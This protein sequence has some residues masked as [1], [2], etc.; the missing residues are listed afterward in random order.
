MTTKHKLNLLMLIYSLGTACL[1]II[2]GFNFTDSILLHT[3][4]FALIL[5]MNRLSYG[6]NRMAGQKTRYSMYATDV[7]FI[8]YL[9]LALILGDSHFIQYKLLIIPGIVLTLVQAFGFERQQS[10]STDN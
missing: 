3:L 7:L 4:L 5:I 8:A 2:Y 9:M 10:K 6:I 1:L